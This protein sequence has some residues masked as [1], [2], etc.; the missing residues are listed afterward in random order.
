MTDRT[1]YILGAAMTAAGAAIMLATQ[2]PV[3]GPLAVVAYVVLHAV[4]LRWGLLVYGGVGG[5][6]ALALSA[7]AVPLLSGS[8]G[9]GPAAGWALTACAV[10]RCLLDPT[11]QSTLTIATGGLVAV[12]FG[13]PAIL[14]P[15]IAYSLFVALLRTA[16][17]ERWEPRRRV[18]QASLVATLIGWA[19]LAVVV[20]L[21]GRFSHLPEVDDFSGVARGVQVAAAVLAGVNHT[22]HSGWHAALLVPLLLAALRPWRAQRRYSD[23]SWLV[24]LLCLLV[25]TLWSATEGQRTAAAVAVPFLAL[26]A[27]ACWDVS[28]PVWLRRMASLLLVLHV[29]GSI[30]WVLAARQ[31]APALPAA[32]RP[33]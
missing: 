15:L 31:P 33:A 2:P 5:L 10:V 16:T 17:A 29:V 1:V 23:A 3:A 25:P 22:D 19:V 12:A 32:V 7:F 21:V 14:P 27:A 26:L 6:A 4:V 11:I 18:L 9:L 30:T 24:A 8:A 20:W 13:S 28:R